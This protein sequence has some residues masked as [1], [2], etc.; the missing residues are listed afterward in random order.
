[1]RVA[2]V[3]RPKYSSVKHFDL[4]DGG[5]EATASEGVSVRE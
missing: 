2:L 1:M 4:T 3:S 5:L